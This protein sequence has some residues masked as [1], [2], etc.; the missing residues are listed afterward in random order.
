MFKLFSVSLFTLLLTGALTFDAAAQTGRKAVGA[1]EVNGTF[2]SIVSAEKKE[3]FAN[4]LKVLALGKGK[5]K[6]AFELVYPHRD[7]SGEMTANTGSLEGTADIAGDTAIYSSDEF[8]PCRITL[9]FV[10]PGVVKVSQQGTDAD[11]GF[12]FNVN[13]DG[14]YKKTSA[15]KPTFGN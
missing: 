9:Q 15:K 11:C 13:A 6:I 7:A 10:K 4:E 5:L 14:T 2:Q 8:G 1:A 3:R 12:G